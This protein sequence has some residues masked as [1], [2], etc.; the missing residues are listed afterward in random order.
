MITLTAVLVLAMIGLSFLRLHGQA[1]VCLA[2][3]LTMAI[4]K[5]AP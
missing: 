3:L 1:V 5:Y 4:V 2:V